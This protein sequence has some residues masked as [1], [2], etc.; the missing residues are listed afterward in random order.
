MERLD[1]ANSPQ[2][3]SLPWLETCEL[4]TGL[5]LQPST[6]GEEVS[7]ENLPANCL[8]PAGDEE[9]AQEA[10]KINTYALMLVCSTDPKG[11]LVMAI[12][13]SKC[14]TKALTGKILDQVQQ[15]AQLLT[16][17]SQTPLGELAYLTENNLSD[18]RELTSPLGET[19]IQR[20]YP[21]ALSA[22]IVDR[23]DVGRI[24]PKGVVGGELV[25]GL[26]EEDI[27]LN[28][29]LFHLR[30]LSALYEAQLVQETL[31]FSAHVAHVAHENIPQ[32]VEYWRELLQGSQ[33][34]TCWQYIPVRVNFSRDWTAA[35]LLIHVQ[36]QHIASSAHEG[37]DID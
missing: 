13:D 21:G 4:R 36:D 25:V 2:F 14:V 34:R 37:I 31:P 28:D 18:L 29:N 20:E 12:F 11:F 27:G 24:L 35:D 19:E 33:Y 6:A 23:H 16:E 32:A 22:Y 5:V 9:A 3:P 7:G 26:A 1:G 15:T 17:Q 30:Q 8:V 10:L